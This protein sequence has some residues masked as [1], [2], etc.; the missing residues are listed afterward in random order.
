MKCN[1]QDQ[2]I[3]SNKYMIMKYLKGKHYHANIDNYKNVDKDMLFGK[4]SK[5]Q[6]CTKKNYSTPCSRITKKITAHHAAES[7]LK[8][9]TVIIKFSHLIH[10]GATHPLFHSLLLILAADLT[11]LLCAES[12]QVFI[13]GLY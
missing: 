12:I 4:D 9:Y 6:Y 7:P 5:L 8:Q 13:V 11:P 2:V 10:I 3:N 1:H